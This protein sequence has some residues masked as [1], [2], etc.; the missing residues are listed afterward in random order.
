MGHAQKYSEIQI[1]LVVIYFYFL[2]LAIQ[3]GIKREALK[4]YLEHPYSVFFLSFSIKYSCTCSL[5][6]RN[7]VWYSLTFKK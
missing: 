5:G 2:N 3:L 1:E 7:K 4:Y 6:F